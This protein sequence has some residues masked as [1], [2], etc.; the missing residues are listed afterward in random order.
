MDKKA[1]TWKLMESL[2]SERILNGVENLDSLSASLSQSLWSIHSLTNNGRLAS[3]YSSNDSVL[4]KRG[5]CSSLGDHRGVTRTTSADTNCD[6]AMLNK[7]RSSYRSMS[8]S[9][10]FTNIPSFHSANESFD[11]TSS[12]SGL[13]ERPHSFCDTSNMSTISESNLLTDERH[14]SLPTPTS[15]LDEDKVYE[16]FSDSNLRSICR[17]NDET[18]SKVRRNGIIAAPP[19]QW[20]QKSPVSNDNGIGSNDTDS[21]FKRADGSIEDDTSL[22]KPTPGEVKSCMKTCRKKLNDPYEPATSSLVESSKQVEDS[23]KVKPFH[24]S[25]PEQNYSLKSILRRTPSPRFPKETSPPTLTRKKSYSAAIDQ[26]PTSS[27]LIRPKCHSVGSI[28]APHYKNMFHQHVHTVSTQHTDCSQY[29]CSSPPVSSPSRLPH[30]EDQSVKLASSGLL[31]SRSQSESS[32]LSAVDNSS[33][34]N[35][36]YIKEGSQIPNVATV[37]EEDEVKNNDELIQEDVQEL[38]ISSDSMSEDLENAS[39]KTTRKPKVLFSDMTEI[40][41]F[42]ESDEELR[43]TPETYDIIPSWKPSKSIVKDEKTEANK[44][45][46]AKSNVETSKTAVDLADLLDLHVANGMITP[47]EPSIPETKIKVVVELADASETSHTREMADTVKKNSSLPEVIIHKTKESATTKPAVKAAQS[48]RK[49][50]H[51]VATKIP[52][53]PKKS[54][55]KNFKT[56]PKLRRENKTRHSAIKRSGKSVQELS[57]LFESPR[58]SQ[59]DLSPSLHKGLTSTPKSI[60]SAKGNQ[61]AYPTSK[62]TK[63][64]PTNKQVSSHTT[65]TKSASP[66]KSPARM[67][68]KKRKE[69]VSRIPVPNETQHIF[70]RRKSHVTVAKRLG[71]ETVNRSEKFSSQESLDTALL[72]DSIHIS[73]HSPVTDTKMNE[74]PENK[75]RIRNGS[76]GPVTRPKPIRKK[77]VVTHANSCLKQNESTFTP[78]ESMMAKTAPKSITE[79]FR[80]NSNS[81]NNNFCET[82]SVLDSGGIATKSAPPVDI[83]SICFSFKDEDI[84]SGNSSSEQK[85]IINTI[86]RPR[87][88]FD[89]SEFEKC[90]LISPL[91]GF[92]CKLKHH[93][94]FSSSPSPIKSPREALFNF[95]MKH[96]WQNYGSSNKEQ[97]EISSSHKWKQIR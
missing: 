88:K 74:K 81:N 10:D 20:M 54:P 55:K 16:Y 5:S 6:L 35:I 52:D 64:V 71:N 68:I 76:S 91:L 65:P 40:C 37:K 12:L 13:A 18:S 44:D 59:S 92:N 90:S 1:H 46:G 73:S 63:K 7:L 38:S 34:F 11:R 75:P 53:S 51:D 69:S 26:N 95:R 97:S 21:F 56:L 49:N 80:N 70:E 28:D 60:T 94:T 15:S 61:L 85:P 87:R 30:N 8:G 4:L 41:S 66:Q 83:D 23:S 72:L 25:L 62:S 48:N 31:N 67:G 89:D 57:K 77:E 47:T 19:L 84:D 17:L 29:P 96:E 58:G 79:V 27:A 45:I 36:T 14:A 43:S 39:L 50:L 78:K 42:D 32:I 93:H 3:K 2:R 33:Y 22:T 82:V 9:A 24:W 86:F